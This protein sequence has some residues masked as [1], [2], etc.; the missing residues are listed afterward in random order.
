[1]ENT[2]P[3]AAYQFGKQ[4]LVFLIVLNLGILFALGWLYLRVDA[5][6]KELDLRQT[7]LLR[8][9]IQQRDSL[10]QAFLRRDSLAQ[11]RDSLGLRPR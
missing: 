1:M 4:F 8:E 2:T 3:S 6:A 11:R 9:G 7:E 5:R 10:Q